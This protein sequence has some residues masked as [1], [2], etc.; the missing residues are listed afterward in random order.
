MNVVKHANAKN[1]SVI[2]DHRDDE[3][4]V[5]VEDDGRGIKPTDREDTDG[6]T[7]LGLHGILERV[8]ALQGELTIEPTPG[9][10]T[11]L[12]VQVPLSEA[13]HV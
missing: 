7:R 9:G 5:V 8:S 11:T 3:L 12:V 10:G 2:V 1:V 6:I 13:V 4:V